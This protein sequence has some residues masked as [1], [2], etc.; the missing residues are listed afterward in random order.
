MVKSTN[1]VMKS[2][3]SEGKS[4]DITSESTISIKNNV[5]SSFRMSVKNFFLTYKSHLDIDCFIDFIVKKFNKHVLEKW[6]V[7][8]EKADK[9]NEYLHS[10]VLLIFNKRLD[11]ID[12]RAFDFMDIHPNIS[13]VE[14]IIKSVRY[15]IKESKETPEN[16]NWRSNYDV[17]QYIEDYIKNRRN[18]KDERDNV[19]DIYSSII[20]HKSLYDALRLES[21]SFKDVMAIKT[22][23]NSKPVIVDKRLEL[24]YNDKELNDWQ[25]KLFDKVCIDPEVAYKQN[26]VKHCRTIRWVCDIIGSRGKSFFTEYCRFKFPEKHF[27]INTS[28]SVKD[29]CDVLRN[30]IF[31]RGI[32]PDHIMIN[33]ARSVEGKDLY[34][35]IEMIKDGRIT[36]TKY[37]GNTYSFFPPHVTVFANWM[38][39][40]NCLTDNRWLIY[41]LSGKRNSTKLSVFRQ[42]HHAKMDKLVEKEKVLKKRLIDIDRKNALKY[43]DS[44]EDYSISGEDTDKKKQLRS[45]GIRPSDSIEI[46]GLH[47]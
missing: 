20:S 36:C 9:S 15:C 6:I 45:K 28:G 2:T 16:P 44:E 3:L 10:H 27:V 35:L 38:P 13:K 1:S 29:L 19:N 47:D 32:F 42:L 31:D 14:S 4:T 25:Q 21:S 12:P 34:T 7:C 18:N 23:Y 46:E 11:I 37:N 22:I 24:I 43:E 41:F 8:H 30:N 26:H 17:I 5:D 33:L 39:K 40:F